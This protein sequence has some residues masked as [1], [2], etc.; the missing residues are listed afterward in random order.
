MSRHQ[1]ELALEDTVRDEGYA[2]KNITATTAGTRRGMDTSST[3]YATDDGGNRVPLNTT[4]D[5]HLEV[6]L[7]EPRLPFGSVHTESLTAEFQ[8]DSVYGIN[9]YEVITTTGNAATPAGSNSAS[10]TGTNNLFKCSTGTTAYS[11]G[12]LQSRSRLRYRAGQGVIGRFTALWSTPAASSIVVAGLGTAESGFYFGY[13]GTSFG[14]LHSTGGVREVQTLTI[15]T[16]STATND[17]QVTLNGV[18]HNVTSTN[19]ASTTATAYEISQGTYIGWTAQARGSTVIFLSNDVG[20]KASTFSLAQSGAATPAAGSFAETNAGVAATDTWIPQASWNGADILDGNGASGITLDP[21]KGN[22]FQIGIQY[23]GFGAVAFQIES[24]YEGNNPDFITVHTLNI[25]NTRTSVTV[26]QPAFPFTMAAYSAG[27]TTDVSISCASYAGF[28]EGPKRLT[29]PR[30]TVF[31]ETNGFVGSTANTYYPLFTIRNDLVH[32]HN[33][34]TA[35]ANQSVVYP[36]SISASHDDATP[37]TFYLIRD[38]ALQGVPSFTRLDSASCIY[39]DKSATTCSF[40]NDG[41]VQFAYTL[42]QSSGGAFAFADE[43][44]LGPGQTMTLAA[45]AVTGSA[46]YVNASLNTREDQ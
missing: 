29:G 2:H 31:R 16:A 25:P 3:I 35:R 27:S 43:I 38:A 34:V 28:I 13:N 6:A 22:V 11:F 1:L 9:P 32:S 15:T 5:G 10:I 44:E 33:G 12:S 23:L 8:T 21:S 14:I 39:V 17:Y 20:N 4:A 45:R 36:L 7:H 26:T 42:G 40:T 18:S 37:I 24:S 30:M 19:N 46:T 41:Q